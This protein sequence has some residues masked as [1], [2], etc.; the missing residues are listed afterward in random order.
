MHLKV[1]SDGGARGNPGPSAIAFLVISDDDKVLCTSTLFLGDHTNN[2]AEYWA[3][4]TALQ[5]VASH[6]PEEVTCYLDSELVVKQLAGQYAV[7]NPEL[8]RLWEKIRELRGL[9]KKV[10]FTSVSR[11]NVYIQKADTLLNQ[12][13]DEEMKK[14]RCKS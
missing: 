5:Y 9:F 12:T 7:R 13:L 2:Q 4:I 6:R 14:C 8:R 10:N 11:T 1:F 3:I